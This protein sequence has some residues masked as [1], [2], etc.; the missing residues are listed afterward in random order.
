MK[1]FFV[2]AAFLMLTLLVSGCSCATRQVVVYEQ[3]PQPPPKVEIISV[4][5]CPKAVWVPGRWVWRGRYRGYVW[6]P[7]HWR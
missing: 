4:R 1:R 5:P 2:I 7:G 3:T 6:V